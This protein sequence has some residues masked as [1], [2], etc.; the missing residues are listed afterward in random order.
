MAIDSICVHWWLIG[1]YSVG[2]CKK[3][4]ATRDFG[5]LRD[6]EQTRRTFHKGKTKTPVSKVLPV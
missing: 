2:Q 6:E 3:C 5:K 4:G 1:D